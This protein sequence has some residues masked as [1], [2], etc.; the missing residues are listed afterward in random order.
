MNLKRMFRRLALVL[1]VVLVNAAPA[2]NAD[3][4]EDHGALIQKWD[5]PSLARGEKLYAAVCITCHGTPEK[6]GTLP[7]S[8]AFWKEPFKNGCDPLSI[9]KTIGA[10]TNQMP[11]QLWMT[12]EQRY[13]VIH[14]LRETFLKPLNPTQY[15]AT[16]PEYLASL[17]KA[18]NGVF[19]K[20]AEMLDYE[21]GPKYLRM[22]F[23]P[24]LSH[25]YELLKGQATG[26]DDHIGSAAYLAGS[27]DAVAS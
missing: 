3:V 4:G 24:V 25:T 14:F 8:R 16:T 20:T 22:D 19:Q 17:P 2:Q 5:A 10:G 12:P 23:G 6:A 15:F 7:T 1:S 27:V 18:T 13:D 21:R 9:Y 26:I 11:P